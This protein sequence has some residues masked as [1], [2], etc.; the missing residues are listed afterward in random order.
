MSKQFPK[1]KI[2]NSVGEEIQLTEREKLV[3]SH[4]ERNMNALGFQIDINTMT[5]IQKKVTEQK[6]FEIPPADY[7]PL[8]VGEGAWAQQLTTYRQFS[9]GDDFGTGVINAGSNNATLAETDVGIDAIN[10]PVINWAKAIGWTLFELQ[11]A[12]FSG[13]WDLI[14]A[15]EQA[16]K[17]NW[18]LGIQKVAFLGYGSIPGLLNQSGITTN[19]TVISK[20]ISAMTAT[21]LNAFVIAILNVYRANCA[22]TAWPTHFVIPESDYLGLAAPSSDTYPLKSKLQILM[23]TFVT[24][25]KNKSF[26]ILP[27]AYGD[28]AYNGLSTNIYALYN[29]DDASLRMDLPVDYTNTLANSNNS[30]SW[31]NVGYGQF[32]GCYA[33]RPLELMY[34]T[35]A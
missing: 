29:Y 8:R 18:D 32:T 14:Q 6:F 31:Q 23:E 28:T 30:F 27:L 33:Y 4:M 12:S 25:T 11:Q 17:K 7:V 34:F 20:N 24:M 2:L 1:M 26:Q 10:V 13:N 21:E 22:R 3:N 19:T 5:A 16:R 15:K 35:H 9:L